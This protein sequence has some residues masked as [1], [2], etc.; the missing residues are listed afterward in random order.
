MLESKLRIEITDLDWT[1]TIQGNFDIVMFLGILYHLRNPM[2]PLM[3]LAQCSQRLVVNT[4]VFFKLDNGTD[5]S[6]QQLGYF[7]E[8]REVN[9]DPTNYWFFTPPGLRMLLKRSGWIVK[10]DFCVGDVGTRSPTGG[11][12]RMYCYCERVSNWRDLRV[13]HD[14]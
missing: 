2:L 8:S 6:D 14:F 13:H 3:A 4:A 10:D 5:V 1:A 7:L 12:A 9:N 11:D